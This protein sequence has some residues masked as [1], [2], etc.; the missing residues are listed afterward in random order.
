MSNRWLRARSARE[1]MPTSFPSSTTGR[2]RTCCRA[3]R[4]VAARQSL[5]GGD[6]GAP[7]GHNVPHQGL[8]RVLLR[9]HAPQ[10]NVRSVTIPRSRR[11][12]PAHGQG[13]HV[14]AAE[15]PGGQGG[16]GGGLDGDHA[17]I[18]QVFDF[19]KKRILS[20]CCVGTLIIPSGRKNI[21]TGP[22]TAS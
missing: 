11:S 10:D 12:S 19:H 20:Q 22:D 14:V 7:P 13:A 6:G 21:P 15:Q 18:H 1:M 17:G 4:R 5:V 2:R 3:I 9:R 16:G 8:G